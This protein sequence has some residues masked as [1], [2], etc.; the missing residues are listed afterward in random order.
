VKSSSR[1]SPTPGQVSG[2]SNVV[3]VAA[4]N[5]FTL[6]VASNGQV[7]AWGDNTFGE[8]GTA[9]SAVASTN[10]PMLVTGIS[11]AVWVSA[12]RFGD[13]L[14]AVVTTNR[15]YRG[16][17]HSLVMTVDGGTNHYWGWGDNT[18]GQIGNVTNGGGTNQIRQYTPAGPL[19]FCTRCQREVQLGTSGSFTAQCNG[20][21]YLYFNTDD[22]GDSYVTGSFNATVVNLTNNVT[23]WATNYA[24]VA[25]GTLTVGN[26]YSYTASGYC[27]YDS[28]GHQSD[29]N[30]IDRVSSNLVNCSFVLLNITNAVCP[31]DQCFSLVGKIQ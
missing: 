20:T 14:D 22:F 30:G 7:Y 19:Q 16:G 26:V 10:R 13:S 5:A 23:V 11:N 1:L 15:G 17:V 3:A 24:G 6:A 21:L 12:P 25:F 27:V 4:G 8:L 29:P 9:S 18:Y 28:Q 2:L 31:S